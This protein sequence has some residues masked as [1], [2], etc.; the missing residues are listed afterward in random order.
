MADPLPVAFAA[1]ETPP[2][3]PMMLELVRLTAPGEAVS[4]HYLSGGIAN[5]EAGR[6]TRRARATFETAAGVAVPGDVFAPAAP[7]TAID[8]FEGRT[9]TFVY[10]TT[11]AWS[12]LAS[13]FWFTSPP[14]AA[15]EFTPDP[16][17]AFG[18]APA[19]AVD[20]Y[21]V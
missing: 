6:A 8:V 13:F 4:Y 17:D 18:P 16:D 12:D 5:Q 10:Q 9:L 2:E 21:F 14:E 11:F 15:G 20:D 19:L 1:I 3:R 7:R